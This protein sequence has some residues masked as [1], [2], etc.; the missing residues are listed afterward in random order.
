MKL[1]LYLLVFFFTITL[2]FDWILLL[3]LLIIIII[4]TF[5]LHKYIKS[6]FTE[7]CCDL[8]YCTFN[9]MSQLDNVTFPGTD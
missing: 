5:T 8:K 7:A 6:P 4:N 9:Y 3:L 2:V 1:V